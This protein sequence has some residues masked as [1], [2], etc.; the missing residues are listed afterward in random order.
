MSLRGRGRGLS[1]V[2]LL[3]G[4]AA[5]CGPVNAGSAFAE[6][7][8]PFLAGRDA[9]VAHDVTSDNTLPFSG[10]ARVVVDLDPALT[11]QEVVDETVAIM[12]HRVED[13]VG[14]ALTVRFAATSGDGTDAVAGA[15]FT[16]PQSG[17]D[18]DAL[19]AEVSAGLG[20]GAAIVALGTGRTVLQPDTSRSLLVTAADA[21]D[22]W[23]AVCDD[24]ALRA[25]VGPLEVSTGTVDVEPGDLVVD[26]ARTTAQVEGTPDE[27]CDRL[28][29]LSE[30]VTLARDLGTVE[31]YDADVDTTDARDPG[32]SITFGDPPSDVSALRE[33]AA[34]LGI[35]LVLP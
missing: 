14:Y 4:A 25:E 33:R 6:E 28:P 8:E 5:G 30:L 13:P 26:P 20:R 18:D 22:V 34:D 12:T 29:G 15:L 9:V 21:L 19:R 24:D 7:V 2:L 32:L 23:A 16:V 27:S 1:A 31:R 17:T 35:E 11:R 3:A 10:S